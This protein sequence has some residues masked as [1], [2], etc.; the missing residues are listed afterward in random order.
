M[1]E[2]K[3]KISSAAVLLLLATIVGVGFYYRLVHACDIKYTDLHLGTEFGHDEYNYLQM[4]INI[5]E[6]GVYGYLS[7]APNAYVTPAYPLF[8]ALCFKIFGGSSPEV[9]FYI[10]IIQAALSA[11][12]IILVFMIG[13]KLRGNCAGLI[14]AAF[15]ALYP[16]LMLYSRYILTET[17]YIFLFLIYLLLQITALEKKHA[18]WH[19]ISG[20]FMAAAVLTRPLIFVL[21]PL[22][23][24]YMQ[25]IE[26]PQ[27]SYTISRFAVFTVGVVTLMLPWWVRNFVEFGKFIPLCTQSNPFYY[28]IMENPNTL[29]PTTNETADGIKLILH[30]L[31]TKPLETLAWYTIG[32]INIIFETQ[33]Y[34]LQNN[35]SPT[36]SFI[37]LHNVIT[38][39]G[40]VGAAMSIFVKKLRLVSLFIFFI[41]L[42][43]LLFIPVPRYA[44][45][46]IPLLSIC[47]AYMLC[48]VFNQ[49]KT[50]KEQNF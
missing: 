50:E 49:S 3:T 41:M 35:A 7:E 43:Q 48:Y 21:I 46:L 9:I 14:A 8:I 13:K 23:Y 15:T 19:Y 26:K 1:K 2:N 4:A 27:L 32:K 6:K 33:D 45:P 20:I 28:G 11:V 17:L 38:V 5:V 39:C 12:S 36:S 42:F 10:K 44:V 40:T 47:G 25:L 22:P 18:A 34:W 37:L 30:S 24:I 16:P 29:P 31:R